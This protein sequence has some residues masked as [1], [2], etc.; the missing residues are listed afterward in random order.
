MNRTEKDRF[1]AG[2][3][4]SPQTFRVIK[5]EGLITG[6]GNSA[7][8]HTVRYRTLM[9]RREPISDSYPRRSAIVPGTSYRDVT[10]VSGIFRR[11]I[12]LIS[13][14][15]QAGNLRMDTMP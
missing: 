12:A 6:D 11:G 2:F 13:G 1:C 14:V 3:S 5:A 10:L 8:T 9:F 15:S 4:Q 7:V